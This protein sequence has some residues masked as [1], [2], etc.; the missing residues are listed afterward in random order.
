MRF[1]GYLLKSFHYEIWGRGIF[2][3]LQRVISE[4][5]FYF[6]PV[7]TSFIFLLYGTSVVV[8]LQVSNDRCHSWSQLHG[9]LHIH[10]H[11]HS[12]GHFHEPA[13]SC[14]VVTF[15]S[16][17]HTHMHILT[18]PHPPTTITHVDLMV[19]HLSCSSFLVS[20]NRVS[21]ARAPAMI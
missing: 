6:P 1:C 11:V 12:V 4:S 16:P 17:Q 21:P 3:W 9:Q 5:F 2:W 13:T 14:Q 10:N 19:I 7:R 15:L 8:F 18:P 20:V